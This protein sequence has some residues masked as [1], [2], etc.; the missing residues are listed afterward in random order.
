LAALEEVDLAGIADRFPDELSGGQQQRIAI[1]RA[2]VGPRRLLLADEPTGALDS[3]TGEDVMRLLRSRCDQGAAAVLVTHDARLA[4]WSDRVIFLR[5]G[6]LVDD[7]GMPPAA[8]S[9][10]SHRAAR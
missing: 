9:L 4:G 2:L 6:E 1:A 5:D 10:L 3:V 8:A 7:T